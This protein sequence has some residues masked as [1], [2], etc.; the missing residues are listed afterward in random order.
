[1]A[2]QKK[3]S[4]KRKLS[5]TSKQKRRESLRRHLIENL[6]NRQL[7]T[8]FNV[9]TLDDRP[10]ARPGD[11]HA[12]DIYGH[13]TLRS[14]ITEANRQAGPHR[15]NLPA[16][17]YQL[18]IPG[19]GNDTNCTGDFDLH[20]DITLAGAGAGATRIQGNS[21]DRVLDIS[22][23][24]SLQDLTVTGGRAPG[25]GQAGNGYGGG[26][27]INSGNVSM[28]NVI[29]T[30]N[31]GAFGTG[32]IDNRGNLTITNSTI[33]NN[34]TPYAAGG[35]WVW[36]GGTANIT[37]ST[38]SGN[39][40]D[41]GGAISAADNVLVTITNSTITGNVARFGG[42]GLRVNDSSTVSL[43][44][45]EITG[46]A[47]NQGG[48]LYTEEYTVV[49]A[50]NTTISGNDATEGGGAYLN[51]TEVADLVVT[52][53]TA[54]N[55]GAGLY[56]RE[57]GSLDGLTITDNFAANDAGGIRAYLGLHT[58]TNLD[59]SGNTAGDDGGGVSA[60]ATTILADGTVLIDGN[61]AE[62]GSGGGIYLTD[63]EWTSAIVQNNEA[64]L[65]D[66]GGVALSPSNTSSVVH[67]LYILGNDA[68]ASGGGVYMSAGDATFDNTEISG[69]HAEARAGGVY[70][71]GV[72]GTAANVYTTLT[73]TNGSISANSTSGFGAAVYI[74]ELCTADLTDMTVEA[75]EGPN[76]A[77]LYL[78]QGGVLNVD[79]GAVISNGDLTNSGGGGA[80]VQSGSLNVNNTDFG[81]GGTDNTP[82]DIFLPS[83]GLTYN[84]DAGAM[85]SCT[86]MGCY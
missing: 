63:T 84:Y 54:T 80:R 55:A 56:V 25:P 20:G 7:L 6:E 38:F 49:A 76:G 1:M 65:G 75:N 45:V 64:I 77:G 4:K 51:G 24:V 61:F 41:N 78:N 50:V 40:A 47:A 33:S 57:N 26:I 31:H 74:S 44:N 27:R 72:S 36:A 5:S 86:E 29:V 60:N 59:I 73:M 19:V 46:N 79:G 48:G 21:L 35:L 69:N 66:G 42:G 3:T 9:T 82:D 2:K 52:A 34:S 30:G 18:S 28:D 53:N 68:E 15:I 8:T 22:G 17:T 85:F 11:G 23:N 58:W 70:A 16:G 32:G 37:N 67:D 12:R 83:V 81:T 43:E 39:T 13:T 71:R 14:A 62:T 10:D